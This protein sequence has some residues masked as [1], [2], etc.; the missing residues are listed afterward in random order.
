M[1]R[2]MQR[3]PLSALWGDMPPD[4]LVAMRESV[5]NHGFV[6]PVIWTYDGLV[7]DGWHRYTISNLLGLELEVREYDGDPVQWV[8]G[9]NLHRRHL[10]AVRRA[11]CV[12]AAL[13]WA[14]QG[15]QHV[16]HTN[17]DD[18]SGQFSPIGVNLI[19]IGETAPQTDA[20]QTGQESFF[21]QAER[22]SMAD[23]SEITQK[24][25][26][27]Y[28]KAGLGPEIRSGEISGAE[29]ER[30]VRPELPTPQPP[31]RVQ[32]LE[33]RLEAKTLECETELAANEALRRELREA[34]AQVSEYPHEREAVASER[35]VIISAQASSIAELQTK[36]NDEKRRAS[37]FEK[38]ARSLGWEAATGNNGY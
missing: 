35:E 8:I 25:S 37:W 31:S 30:R 6:D 21:T 4:E 19:P 2:T 20:G 3:H 32:R 29:A 9:R 27:R 38:Q 11:S 34:K 17:R 22:A 16:M 7:L 14:K 12:S 5:E 26:D 13:E 10:I 15:H 24:R 36:L 1:D 23:V 28:E 18:D 33:M